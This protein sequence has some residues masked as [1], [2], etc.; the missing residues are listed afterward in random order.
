MPPP[1]PPRSKD[2]AQDEGLSRMKSSPGHLGHQE[3][4]NVEPEKI[5]ISPRSLLDETAE[6]TIGKNVVI[7]GKLK[8]DRLVRIDGFFSGQLVSQGNLVVGSEGKLE[9]DVDG[10]GSVLVDGRVVGNITADAVCL[11]NQVRVEFA[12]FCVF[13]VPVE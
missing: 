3:V 5:V 10:M 7:T 13:S 2:M 12:Y 9:G 6:T 11:R 8:F 4:R 1:L